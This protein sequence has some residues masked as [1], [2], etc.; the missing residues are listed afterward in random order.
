MPIYMERVRG[1][2]HRI[3]IVQFEEVVDRVSI[4]PAKVLSLFHTKVGWRSTIFPAN[5]S[6][7]DPMPWVTGLGTADS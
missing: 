5:V 1:Y 7:S 2:S 6:D 3:C 4:E